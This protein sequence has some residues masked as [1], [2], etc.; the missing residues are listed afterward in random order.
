MRA[1]W[2]T[3]DFMAKEAFEMRGCVLGLYGL[4]GSL[5]KLDIV[6]EDDLGF[7]CAYL[8]SANYGV[9]NRAKDEVS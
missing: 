2:T 1:G 6:D 4:M 9:S 3:E 8:Y 5:N 7:F